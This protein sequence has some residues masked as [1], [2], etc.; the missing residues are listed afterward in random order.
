MTPQ[1]EEVQCKQYIYYKLAKLK[2]PILL[3]HIAKAPKIPL[4]C[5]K[6]IEKKLIESKEDYLL[7]RFAHEIPNADKE[8]LYKHISQSNK[9]LRTAFILDFNLNK[10][11]DFL[12]Y[13]GLDIDI[14]KDILI[15]HKPNTT[16]ALLRLAKCYNSTHLERAIEILEKEKERSYEKQQKCN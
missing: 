5:V 1:E 2:N 10:I 13:T 12:Y 7:F 14:C 15:N 3:V 4:S 16:K 6:Q 8:L 11:N 9:S